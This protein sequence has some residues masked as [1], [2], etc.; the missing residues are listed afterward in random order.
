MKIL[1]LES[2]CD[3]SSVA[4]LDDSQGFLFEESHS[5]I[6][7]HRPY[8]G[9]VPELATRGHL[10]H[11]PLLLRRW[12]SVCG[13]NPDAIAVTVG[14]G[15]A[16]CLAMGLAAARSLGLLFDCKVFGINHLHGHALSPFLP[17][18][19]RGE[20]FAE[21]LPHL[22]LLVS[23]GNSLLFSIDSRWNFK[24]LADTVDDAAGEALDKGAKLL[25]LPYPGGVEIERLAELGDRRAFS[26]PIAFA[27]SAMKFS[28]AGLKTSLRYRLA[29]MA[30]EEIE[31]RRADLCA[32]YQSAVVGALVGK[33]A[34]ALLLFPPSSIGLSGGVSQNSLLRNEMAA[35]AHGRGLPLL[36][37]PKH[38][39][40]DNASMIAFAALF[41]PFRRPDP[42]EIYPR[43]ALAGNG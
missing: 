43:M 21:F 13:K 18:W 39:C 3:D 15:L 12:R 25:R 40:G 38:Y 6:S 17:L 31:G 33:M 37:A 7:L 23:G 30:P 16:G 34:K 14:P 27:G 26:F 24:I 29:S 8:G 9:V 42:Q 2:S 36:A 5:Q 19:Q 35:L 4:F 10:C 32:S 1:A 20:S 11:I 41:P 28:C 22:G